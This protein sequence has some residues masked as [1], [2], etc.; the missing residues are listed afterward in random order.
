LASSCKRCPAIAGP[1]P[2]TDTTARAGDP[3]NII[4]NRVY[5]R[6]NGQRLWLLE[7]SSD[8]AV[9]VTVDDGRHPEPKHVLVAYEQ[10]VGSEVKLPIDDL[11]AYSTDAYADEPV[12]IEVTVL[13]MY[14]VRNRTYSQ[15]LA[16]A[17]GIGA[18]LS[19]AY[20]P[21]ISAASQV[22]KAVINAKQDRV[23]AKFTFELYPWKSGRL[24][25]TEGLGVP[26]V[27]YGQYLL[28]NAPNGSEIGDPDHIHLDY[29]LIPYRVKPPVNG[30][31][32]TESAPGVLRQ[33]PISP[34]EDPPREPL[35]LT[36]VILTVDNTKLSNALQIIARADAANRVLAELAKDVAI[37]P[38]KVALVTEQLD[39][40]KSKIRLQLAQ[41]EFNR[42]KRQPEAV[43]RLFAVYED[44]NLSE[45]DK[46]AVLALIRGV[47]P[48]DALAKSGGDIVKLKTWYE[49]NKG[50]LVYDPQAGTYRVRSGG[51]SGT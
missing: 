23:L 4:I 50:V 7:N 15:V 25:V 46:T 24:R 27:A 9:V 12:R 17:A 18:A 36:Y 8:I 31:V 47:L 33:W 34:S 5:L 13:A 37:T 29:S 10:D 40:L 43:G 20:A 3:L 35:E 32:A 26:R 19:P 11:I 16:A 38:G 28:L 39:D 2:S 45:N 21:A 1:R 6:E 14:S 30:L 48:P 49:A 42:H 51:V 44:K 41:S 22:G